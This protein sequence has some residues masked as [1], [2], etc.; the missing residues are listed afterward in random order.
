MKLFLISKYVSCNFIE[1]F[2]QTFYPSSV[3]SVWIL[4]S[5]IQYGSSF[6]WTIFVKSNEMVFILFY[7]GNQF[8]GNKRRAHWTITNQH[9]C[10]FFTDFVDVCGYFTDWGVNEDPPC[11]YF[12]L[13]WNMVPV[14]VVVFVECTM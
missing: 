8:D 3:Y 4:T 11:L 1:S 9:I 5:S 12:L 2:L 10:R 6:A 7:F 14:F 13:L